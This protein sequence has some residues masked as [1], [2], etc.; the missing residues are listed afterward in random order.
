MAL[1][2]ATASFSF[3]KRPRP[4]PE[5]GVTM[6]RPLLLV[7]GACALEPPVEPKAVAPRAD[8][9]LRDVTV[10]QYRGEE[11]RV[12]ATA[13]RLELMRGSNDFAAEDAGIALVKSGVVI[14]SQQVNGNAAAQVATGTRGVRFV[15]SDG[16]VGT[17]ERATWERAAAPEGAAWSDAGVTVRHPRYDLDA[18]GFHADFAEQR[19]A[20][21]R[22]VSRTKNP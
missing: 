10:R 9:T 12:T 16:T 8:V 11:L 13:P 21:D 17:T 15:G 3:L 18:T 20:F 14:L 19:V 7:C 6:W 22:P 1:S 4:L 5:C 2:P